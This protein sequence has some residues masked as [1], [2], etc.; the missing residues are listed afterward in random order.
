[1]TVQ[2][3][4]ARRELTTLPGSTRVPTDMSAW[5]DQHAGFATPASR[6]N[7]AAD[8]RLDQALT[9]RIFELGG[10]IGVGTDTPADDYN[11]PG[12]GLHRELALLVR[13][14][15]TPVA[16]LHAATGAAGKILGRPN[17]GTLRPGSITYVLTVAGD[18]TINIRATR[19][20]RFVLQADQL[21]PT[22]LL[23]HQVTATA[24]INQ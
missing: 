14:G 21:L 15:L 9:R 3:D 17:L 18:P 7:A 12:G 16:D 22:D 10:L 1:M 8:L 20:V 5:F 19:N 23:L 11:L 6:T 4:S 13:A 2:P 24:N